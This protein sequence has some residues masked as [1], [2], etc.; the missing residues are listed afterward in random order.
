MTGETLELPAEPVVPDSA[1]ASSPAPPEAP[2]TVHQAHRRPLGVHPVPLLGG[3]GVLALL[4][5]V[6]L[7]AGPSVVGGLVLGVLA[8]ALLTLFLAG[9]R[10][11]PDAPFGRLT[12]RAIDRSRSLARLGAVTIRALGRAAVDLLRIRRRQ[13]R[14]RGQLRGRLQPLGE[15]VYRDDQRRAEALKQQAAQLE[16]EL[17]ETQ[18]EASGVIASTKH[19]IER[20]RAM[21]APPQRLAPIL[22][23]DGGAPERSEPRGSADY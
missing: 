3:L 7:L 20:E 12:L 11:E 21:A 23:D 9:V 22:A 2:A 10:R 8:I 19:E 18:L 17:R 15:A 1:V 4:V 14:L 5:A 16:E 13:H 6:V